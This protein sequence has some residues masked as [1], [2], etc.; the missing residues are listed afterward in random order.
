VGDIGLV[1]RVLN[2]LVKKGDHGDWLKTLK[3]AYLPMTEDE[4]ALKESPSDPIYPV[5]LIVQVRKVI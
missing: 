5:R 2:K 1:L 4:N 3:D